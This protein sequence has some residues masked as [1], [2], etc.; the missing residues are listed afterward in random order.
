MAVPQTDS[1]YSIPQSSYQPW[2]CDPVN[3]A[4]GDYLFEGSD[5]SLGGGEPNGLNLVRSYTS[6]ENL[7]KG[8]LGFGWRH[9]YEITLEKHSDGPN[10]LGERSPVDT[11]SAIAGLYAILDIL[12]NNTNNDRMMISALSSKGR[13]KGGRFYF[14][15]KE[16]DV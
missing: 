8:P 10:A 15:D 13:R 5:L 4:S 14:I 6:G 7:E 1:F 2:S 11:A 16:G 3:M 12:Y 9:G